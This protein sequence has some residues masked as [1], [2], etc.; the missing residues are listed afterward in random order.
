MA[1]GSTQPLTKTS[2]RNISLGGKGGQCVG[3]RNL[4][5][6]YAEFLEIWEPRPTG[7]HRACLGLHRDCSFSLPVELTEMLQYSYLR[8]ICK[9]D[10][11]KI[12]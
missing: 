2:T 12:W 11:R 8:R 9:C 1:L 4:P 7:P 5:H 10:V 3:L 6:S